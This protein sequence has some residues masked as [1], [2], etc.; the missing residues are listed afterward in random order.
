M[1]YPQDR[2]GTKARRFQER[3]DKEVKHVATARK[4]VATMHAFR[5]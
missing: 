5:P 4:T 2:A 1:P 3:Q